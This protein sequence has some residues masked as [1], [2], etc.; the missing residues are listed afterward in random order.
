MEKLLTPV[1][2]SSKKETLFMWVVSIV[3]F[4]LFIITGIIALASPAKSGL[5]G[6]MYYPGSGQQL[7][8]FPFQMNHLIR[9]FLF[10]L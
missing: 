2:G 3:L 5:I 7:M 8:Y 10:L 4:L 9:L 6:T 1:S